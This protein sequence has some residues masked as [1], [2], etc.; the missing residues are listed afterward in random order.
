MLGVIKNS[1]FGAVE[2]WPWTVLSHGGTDDVPYEERACEGGKFATVEVVGK[3]FD[4]ALREAMPKVVK[5]AGGTNE[6]GVG[7]GMS[8]PVS[9]LVFPAEDG[10]FQQKVKVCFR[11]PSSFQANPPL[12]TDS[13]IQIEQREPMTVFSSQFGGF[14][15]EADY[16]ARWAQLHSVLEGIGPLRRDCCYFT[17]YDPPMKPFGRRNEVWLVRE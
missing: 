7:M 3:P 16:A 15:K 17:G 11:I 14:A 12:P 5:Y 8:V 6:Q 13:S 1:L 4:E 10:S 2:T 9:F